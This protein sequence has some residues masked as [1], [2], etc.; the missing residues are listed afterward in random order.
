MSINVYLC[1][2]IFLFILFIIFLYLHKSKSEKYVTNTADPAPN[3]GAFV[4]RS[5]PIN[6]SF[7]GLATGVKPNTL[8]IVNGPTPLNTNCI[9]NLPTGLNLWTSLYG[10]ANIGTVP[11]VTNTI[12][13]INQSST[14][15]VFHPVGGTGNITTSDGQDYVL[16]PKSSVEMWAKFTEKTNSSATCQISFGRVVTFTI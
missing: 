6:F 7:S 11:I 9:L 1:L 13:I 5:T 12:V 16:S 3:S 15:V 10:T 8:V 4:V 2:F 14:S